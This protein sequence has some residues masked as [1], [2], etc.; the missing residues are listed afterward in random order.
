[1][2]SKGKSDYDEGDL[3][4]LSDSLKERESEISKREKFIRNI[5][6]SLKNSVDK[7][8]SDI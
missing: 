6:L 8:M 7:E 1:M 5:E 4:N 2:D 3:K